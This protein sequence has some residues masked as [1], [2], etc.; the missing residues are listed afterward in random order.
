MFRHLGCL[1]RPGRPWPRRETQQIDVSREIPCR[2]LL[3]CSS[4][5]PRPSP[6]DFSP[7][8]QDHRAI[9]ILRHGDTP[10]GMRADRVLADT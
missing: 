8:A 3:S 6:L 4:F 5:S 9:A 7:I 1:N 2:R 10:L